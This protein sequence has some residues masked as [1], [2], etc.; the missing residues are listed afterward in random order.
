MNVRLIS[1]SRLRAGVRV[2]SVIT[3]ESQ[4][5]EVTDSQLAACTY[6]SRGFVSDR[7]TETGHGN[8]VS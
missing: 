5:A 1:D 8:L 6:F 2:L 4:V 7:F 3:V